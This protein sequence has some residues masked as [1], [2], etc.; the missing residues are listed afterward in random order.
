MRFN[1]AYAASIGTIGALAVGLA[2]FAA[3]DP[4]PVSAPPSGPALQIA[5]VAPEEP[6]VGV[7]S[8]MDV[9]DLTDGYE[10]RPYAPASL[11]PDVAWTE[12]EDG[13]EESHIPSAPRQEWSPRLDEARVAAVQ[14]V[15]E[16][17]ERPL[18]FGFD[19]PR[20]DYAQERRQRREAMQRMEIERREFGERQL[21]RRERDR[22]YEVANHEER[23]PS[24]APSP[25][26]D[27][28]PGPRVEE[29]FY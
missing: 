29:T 20:P 23:Q 27:R 19:R 22:R 9:G 3:K 1:P 18:S 26:L 25:D 28:V 8:V 10:H 21:A 14:F 15:Q 13:Y 2:A 4:R 17:R 12:A 7:G 6:K 24:W 11:T 16:V 5:L